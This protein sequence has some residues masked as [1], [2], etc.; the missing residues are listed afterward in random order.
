MSAMSDFE[1]QLREA[2]SAAV[3]DAQPPSAVM[4]L[5]L[6]RHRRR[7]ARVGGASAVALAVLVAV[8]PV[9]SA[10]RGGGGQPAHRRASAALLF[11]GGG[12]ILLHRRGILEWLYPDGRT[13]QVASGFAGATL[14]GGKLLAWKNVNPPGA[15][16]F[17]PHNCFDPECTRFYGQSYYTMNLDGSDARLVLPAERPVGNTE[18][19]HQDVQLSPDGLMLGY[20][21]VEQLRN[22]STGASELWSINLATRRKTDLGPYSS[23]AFAWRDSTAILAQSADGKALQ[24]VTVNNG[25]RTTYLTVDNPRLIRAYEHARPGNGPPLSIGLG[26]WSTGPGPSA[27]AVT[28]AGRFRTGRD[29]SMPAEFLIEKSRILAFA[30]SSEPWISLTLQ[31]G[32]NGIFLLEAQSGKCDCPDLWNY[33]TYAGTVQSEQLSR[34]QT[35]G[36]PWDAAVFNPAG[37]VIAFWYSNGGTIGF[38]PVAAAACGRAGRCL[39]FQPKPL[40]GRGTLLAWAP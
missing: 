17:L 13:V 23:G 39:H 35:F 7:N 4:E 22:S 19:G 11:P 1:S 15:S 30:P 20:V 36:D 27:L 5:V 31:W 14:D 21:R 6:R 16:R 40:F 18:I 8:V 32:P 2:M 3:A 24:L 12:R 25:N 26:G 10:L 28:L 33:V 37:N 34:Q 9:A 29:M 38:V